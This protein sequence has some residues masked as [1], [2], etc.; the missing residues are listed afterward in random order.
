MKLIPMTDF[1]LEQVVKM[2]SKE[3]TYLRIFNYAKFLKQPLT[4]G[5]FVPCDEN[6]NILENP[7]KENGR[8]AR[9]IYEKYQKA[10]EKVLFKGF[11]Y[12]SNFSQKQNELYEYV[13]NEHPH[14]FSFERIKNGTVESLLTG[15]KKEFLIELTESAIKQ[16]GL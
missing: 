7:F 3:I 4:L 14:V 9:G 13:R 15:Y 11:Y 10:K 6:G 1:V 5:M 12:Q 2:E 8:P 16:I